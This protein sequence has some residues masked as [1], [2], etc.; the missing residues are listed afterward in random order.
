MPIGPFL[1]SNGGDISS[2]QLKAF[3]LIGGKMIWGWFMRENP[4]KIDDN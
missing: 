2:E 4:I 1:W 3:Q